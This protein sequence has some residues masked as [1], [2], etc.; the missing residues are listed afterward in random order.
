MVLLGG[1]SQIAGGA[2]VAF[3]NA[4]Q[5]AYANGWQAGDNGGAG[6]GPWTFAF[7]GTANNLV[8]PPQFIDTAPLAANSLGAPAF[9]LTTSDQNNQFDTSEVRRTL[10]SPLA[11][12][13]TLSVDIDGSALANAPAFTIGNTFDL[14]GTNGSERFSLLTNNGYNNDHWTSTNG[15]D[16]GIPAAN[17]FRIEFTLVTIDSF[18]LVLSPIGGGAPYFAQTGVPLAGTA[19]IAIN[20]IRISDYGTGSSANGSMELFFNNLAVTGPIPGDLNKD[21]K[22]DAADYVEWRNSGLDPADY[23]L[24]RMHFG[25]TA[26]ASGLDTTRAAVPEPAGAALALLWG[27][28]HVL[29]RRRSSAL[30]KTH[31]SAAPEKGRI[32][33]RP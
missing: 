19:G 17:S 7:S 10:L 15:A 20:R 22:V 28:T 30:P 31:G 18:D 27:W 26:P 29:F 33:H 11:V 6:F 32:P 1:S 24:W 16:T 12:G 23:T 2:T 21:N 4:S 8:H 14:F 3:D 13:Q 25:E 5:T 9:A